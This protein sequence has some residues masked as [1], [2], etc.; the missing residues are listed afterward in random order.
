MNFYRFIISYICIILFIVVG[1]Q[2]VHLNFS[3]DSGDFGGSGK[4]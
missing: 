1:K 3:G 2:A 4:L